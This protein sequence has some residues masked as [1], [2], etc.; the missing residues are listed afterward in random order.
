[1]HAEIAREDHSANWLR[2]TRQMKAK[3]TCMATLPD[4]DIGTKWPY[5][6][7]RLSRDFGNSPK[8]WVNALRAEIWVD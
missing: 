6:C 1:M 4:L 3:T 5:A 8:I 2:R 7:S